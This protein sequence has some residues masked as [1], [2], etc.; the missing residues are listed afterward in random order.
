MND[1]TPV[2]PKI[3]AA[4]IIN[5]SPVGRRGCS[6]SGAFSTTLSVG[7]TAST[8]GKKKKKQ[9]MINTVE[10]TTPMMVARWPAISMETALLPS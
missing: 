4:S 9:I 3:A 7:I 2:L 6:E 10:I 1:P 8:L 5:N